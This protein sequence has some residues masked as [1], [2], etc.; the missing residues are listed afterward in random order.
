[1]ATVTLRPD[2]TFYNS[3]WTVTSAASAHAAVNDDSDSSYVSGAAG[4]W[5]LVFDLGPLT[6][7]AYAQIRSV[8][9]RV[10]RRGNSSA[11]LDVGLQ[12]LPR[13]G[14][15][16]SLVLSAGE[17]PSSTIA[18]KT[19]GSLVS[20]PGGAAWDN[21]VVVPNLQVALGANDTNIRV[22]EVYVDVDYDQAPTCVVTAPVGTVTG[23]QVPAVE[24][25][26][27]DTEGASLERVQAKVF[28]AAQHAAAGFG[29]DTSSAF[30]DSGSVLTSAQSVAVGVPLPPGDYHVYVRVADAGSGGRYG[31]WAS[32]DF[33]MGGDLPATPTLTVASDSTARSNTLTV[34]QRDNLLA[35]GQASTATAA[36]EGDGW[37]PDDNTTLD[38]VSSTLPTVTTLDETFTGADGALAA[39]NT[40]INW[41][42]VAGAFA[43]AS[44]QLTS[45]NTELILPPTIRTDSDLP[46]VDHYAQVVVNTLSTT[47]DRSAH[48]VLRMS[49]SAY[50]GYVVELNQQHNRFAVWKAIAGVGHAVSGFRSLPTTLTLP[51]TWR[52]EISGSTI[53]VY[54]NG[55]LL[56]QW[57]D[58]QIT[59]G[60]RVGLGLYNAN[61]ISRVDT[62]QAGDLQPV[63]SGASSGTQ[64]LEMTATAA[65][66]GRAFTGGRYGWGTP[67]T[68][69][70]PLTLTASAWQTADEARPCRADVEWH[71]A[72]GDVLVNLVLDEP[73]TG[74][75]GDPWDAGTWTDGNAGAAT[76]TIQ[77]NAGRLVTGA[78]AYDQ[79]ARQYAGG[80][81]SQ[82]D[83][84]VVVLCRPSSTSAEMRAA[85]C[86]RTDGTW[87][88]ANPGHPDTGY[89][90][91]VSPDFGAVFLRVQDGSSTVLATVSLTIP[92]QGVWVRLRAHGTTLAL[93]AWDASLQE[94]ATWGWLG[95]DA[96][97]TS[98]RVA[99]TGQN[100]ADAAVRT[101]TF[102]H[103]TVD[104]LSRHVF[105][106]PFTTN[107]DGSLAGASRNLTVPADAAVA[108]T[109]AVSFP[110]GAGETFVWDKVGLMPGHDRPWS[111]G[112][113]TVSNLYG[114]NESTFEESAAGAAGW[115]AGDDATVARAAY[116][117]PPS[118]AALELSWDGSSG[119]PSAIFAYGPGKPAEAGLDYAVRA[120]LWRIDADVSLLRLGLRFTDSSDGELAQSFAEDVLPDP[121]VAWAETAHT[122]RAPAGT[123]HV[124]AALATSAVQSGAG[125][126]TRVHVVQGTAAPEVF[127]PGPAAAGY[128]LAEYSDDGGQTWQQV[129]GTTGAVYGDDRTAAVH[130]YETPPGAAR[131]YRASTA[132]V[133]YDVDSDGGATVVSVPSD[134]VT[135]TLPADGFWLRDPLVPARL[136]AVTIGGDLESSSRQPQQVHD[137]LGREHAVVVSD[138][139]KGEEFSLPLVFKTA[140]SYRQFEE[141]R[142]SG[143]PLL[144]QSDFG[145]QWYVRLGGERR[146]VLKISV[147]RL[148]TPLRLVEVSA[149]EVDRP[150]PSEHDYDVVTDLVWEIV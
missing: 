126:I 17:K 77:A 99:L 108:K 141:L 89:W 122:M 121:G 93:K 18:T 56:G 31:P 36:G 135:A 29:P 59:T 24:F 19:Y 3:G 90:A 81:D 145:E 104:D 72:D 109:V 12:Y 14:G 45:S 71:G 147:V 26:Y 115:T 7:P 16:Q 20:A 66:Q 117:V 134:E 43:V 5:L 54:L 112:G 4:A 52:G 34:V 120:W 79:P 110:T 88:G 82:D 55:V 116:V 143:G 48:V 53:S 97:H 38:S 65:R 150:D 33:T 100:G 95:E 58:T 107:T 68:P 149:V 84:E 32:A 41:T 75:D 11:R 101:W 40:D 46:S 37:Y 39:A 106:T 74:T 91:E 140:G 129:R 132:A 80:M 1:M 67:V 111:R 25:S 61:S 70:D 113:L 63:V 28:T 78:V 50:T 8:A 76:A 27:N 130:D 15:Y 62:F 22:H 13:A 103:L 83:C 64:L 102:D 47:V 35:A 23:T 118:G 21:S 92:A 114:P 133:D 60:T 148:D 124:H 136:L 94:P 96:T 30:W 98:G 119:L 144:F 125:A 44:N 85:V 128:A 139:V 49:P 73:F 10:R 51:A 87:N 2:G 9:V 138:V 57:T 42:V 123:A 86:V 6:L 142:R 105:G 69:G 127:Q 146:T 131:T 137:T